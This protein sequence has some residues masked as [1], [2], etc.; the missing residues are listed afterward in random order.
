MT[1][2]MICHLAA[3]TLFFSSSERVF[4]LSFTFC[5][6]NWFASKINSLRYRIRAQKHEMPTT[7]LH[8]VWAH[9]FVFTTTI[10]GWTRWLNRLPK[11]RS[12]KVINS[13]SN[14]IVCVATIPKIRLFM[15]W[16]CLFR[17]VCFSC[18]CVRSCMLR[19][20][21]C[22]CVGF[23]VCVM[24]STCVWWFQRSYVDFDV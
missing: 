7:S 16:C 12:K 15:Q 10:E 8:T 11:N 14:V 1:Q 6:L 21:G 4:F 23:N 5:H 3:G 24:I 19:L 13:N 22:V 17:L 20:S 18:A 2:C 9:N